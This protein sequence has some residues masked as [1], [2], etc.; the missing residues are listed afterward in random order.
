MAGFELLAPAAYFVT[1][2]R[3]CDEVQ[4]SPTPRQLLSSSYSTD[5]SGCWIMSY[6]FIAKT[7]SA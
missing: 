1:K 2:F 5:P 6:V 4:S 3:F 7:Y